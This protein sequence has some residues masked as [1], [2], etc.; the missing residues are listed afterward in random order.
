MTNKPKIKRP[1]V[2]Q[3]LFKRREPFLFMLWTAIAGISIMFLALTII[4]SLRKG[5]HQ[6]QAVSLPLAFWLSTFSIITSSLTL[7]QTN[8]A[9][10][11]EQFRRA[12]ILLGTTLGLGLLFI[13][14]QVVGWQQL[15]AQKVYL[16]NSLGGSFIY[17]ISGLHIAHILGGILFL[18]LIFIDIARHTSY[19]DSFI[20]SINPPNQL[21]LKLV[22]IYWHFVDV[23]WLYLFLFFLWA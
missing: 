16:S 21:R 22:T 12:K 7:W 14:L 15:I 18:T 5:Q 6:W 2:E 10:K 8:Q 20:H 3:G 17:I 4:Y 23:L 11:K 1:S 9:V 19:V 13:G